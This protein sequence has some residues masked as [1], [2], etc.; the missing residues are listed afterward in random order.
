MLAEEGPWADQLRQNGRVFIINR[1][2]NELKPEEFITATALGELC[3]ITRQSL[4]P[5]IR[6]MQNDLLLPIIK[7]P[8]GGYAYSERVDI[9]PF[10]P[11]S[12]ALCYQLM[13]AIKSSSGF[14]TKS[15]SNALKMT[16]KRLASGLGEA[17]DLDFKRMDGCLS[18]ANMLTP[19]FPAERIQF[20]WRAAVESI[21]VRLLYHTPNGE[22]KYRTL[23][24][25]HVRK[26]LFDWIAICYDHYSGEFRRFSLSRMEEIKV[27]GKTFAPHKNFNLKKE[28][29]AFETFKT[30]KKV[31]AKFY[32]RKQQANFIREHHVN[33]DTGRRELPC[34]GL[35]LT[36]H[37]SSF[38]DVLRLM[39]TFGSDVV[40][41]S[42]PEVVQ[43][44]Y[45]VATRMA[46]DAAAV[47]NGTFQFDPPEEKKA[48]VETE[49]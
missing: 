35:E 28:N 37:V 40:P 32:F 23:D 36:L 38:V 5:Y 30:D 41:L 22:S 46:A 26:L 8:K 33:C 20:F 31:D 10:M 39:R 7:G 9:I 4:E 12:E 3:G 25:L 49:V 43:E 17:Q 1:A 18:F 34:G 16:Y 15:Q 27:T 13:L 14:C 42:P 29:D 11:I 6:H 2:L 48:K 45:D 19:K 24:V 21:Q 44:W 47:K